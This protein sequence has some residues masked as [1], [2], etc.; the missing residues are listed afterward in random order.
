[1]SAQ[2]PVAA[3]LP[4]LTA[5]EFAARLAALG[6]FERPPRLAVAVSGGPDSMALALLAREWVSARGGTIRALVVDHG[7]RS[8]SVCESAR[9]LG[10]LAQLGVPARLLIW[11]GRKPEA[12]LQ[13]RARRMRLVMLEQACAEAGILHLLL[14]HHADDQAETVAMRSARNS[15]IEGLAGMGAV[16]ETARVRILRPL[17]DVPKA[18]L[19]ATVRAYGMAW[20]EDPSNRDPR[21]ERARLR[22][23]SLPA[24]PFLATARA[25]ARLR[26]AQEEASLRLAVRA[27]RADPERGSVWIA[28]EALLEVAPELAAALLRRAL[29]TVG[30]TDYPPER[31]AIDRLLAQVRQKNLRRTTLC[32]CLIAHRGSQLVITPEPARRRNC[33]GGFRSLTS[34]PFWPLLLEQPGG[35]CM[36]QEVRRGGVPPPGVLAVQAVGT[37]SEGRGS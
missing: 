23:A 3:D 33:G 29:A 10:R 1:M 30:G 35:L 14:A 11:S 26:S 28:T 20:E 9:V 17:L 2:L 7:L 8:E 6:P 12:R 25:A 34:A 13:E 36:M 31:S 16:R 37:A 21:F 4:P 27:I 15:G 24:E 22:A 5:E 32:R 19:I 18:R